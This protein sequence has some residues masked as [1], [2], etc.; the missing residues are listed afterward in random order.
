MV[1]KEE[2]IAHLGFHN[3]DLFAFL[4]RVRK[5]ITA[6]E[7]LGHSTVPTYPGAFKVSILWRGPNDTQTTWFCSHYFFLGCRSQA[8]LPTWHLFLACRTMLK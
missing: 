6:T 1:Y 7:K 4:T 5:A 3:L 2:K 8:G